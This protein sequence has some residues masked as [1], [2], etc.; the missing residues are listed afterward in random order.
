MI[1]IG[2]VDDHPVFR[3]GLRST[4][5][6]HRDLRVLWD[7]GSSSELLE[8]LSSHPVDIVLMDLN[9]GSNH[10]GF[11]AT[12]SVLRAHPQLKVIVVSASLD[13]ETVLAARR[14]GASGYLAKDLPVADVV[15][16]VRAIAAPGA[17]RAVYG[18]QLPSG[19]AT[20]GVTWSS[21]R[22]LTR[23]ESEVLSE[24]R[25]GRGNREI[26]MRLGVS[27]TTVNKH[28]Q[29]VLKK[30]HAKTRGEAVARIRADAEASELQRLE[31]RG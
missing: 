21:I 22:G 8:T 1:R 17:R 26:A 6:R 27:I 4:L 11:A 24:L 18:N 31:G 30:L 12:R 2:I 15:E 16:A 25:R 23:R 20:S 10:D 3:L 14:S 9:L 7:L 5:E 29:Q 19:S 28:V 13:T